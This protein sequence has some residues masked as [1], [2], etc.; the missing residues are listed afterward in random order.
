VYLEPLL[1]SSQRSRACIVYHGIDEPT[2]VRQPTVVQGPYILAVGRL[3]ETKGIEVLIR[4]AG[5][6]HQQLR[7]VRVAVVGDGPLRGQLEEL[8]QKLNIAAFVTFLGSV[9]PAAVPQLMRESCFVVVPSQREAFGMVCLEAMVS[10]KAVVGS[11]V[12]GIP[13]IVVDGETGILVPPDNPAA[14][15]SAIDLLLQD[16][17]QAEA[18]GRRG[19]ERALRAFTWDRTVGAYLEAYRNALKC[20]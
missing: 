7:N 2:T 11:R 9:D 20:V 6:L 19:R 14:L 4:S 13:E 8:A 5:M 15:A 1:S 18:M 3:V 17:P 10:S 12:G 16:P